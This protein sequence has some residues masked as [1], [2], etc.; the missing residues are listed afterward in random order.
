MLGAPDAPDAGAG[1]G[2]S[3]TDGP[4]FPQTGINATAL[5]VTGAQPASGPFGGGNTIVVRGSGFTDD[6][7]VFIGGRMVQPADTV[8]QD[9]NS[10]EVVVPAGRSGSVS[11]EVR[12]GDQS[13]ASDDAYVYNPIAIEP[14]SGSIAGGTS[15]LISTET[16]RFGDADA[17][18]EFDGKP[19]SELQVITPSQARCK[20]PP[21]ASGAVDISI[22]TPSAIDAPPLVASN[23]FEYR[24]LTD[25]DRGGLN[26]GPISGT[27]NV[28]VVDSVRGLAIPDAFV[29]INDTLAGPYQGRTDS[30]GQITFSGDDLKGRISVH[31]AAKCMERSSIIS[32]DAANVTVHVAPIADPSCADLGAGSSAPGRGTAGSFISGELVFGGTQEFSSLAWDA[33]PRPRSNEVRVAYVFTTRSSPQ[34]ANPTPSLSGTLARVLEATPVL[35]DRGYLYRIFARPAMLAVY[36]IAGVERRD[37]GEFVPYV[38]GVTPGVLTSPGEEEEGVDIQMNI[39]LDRDLQVELSQLPHPAGRSPKYFRMRTYLDLGAEGALVRQI[40][41]RSLDTLTSFEPGKPFRFFAQPALVGPL[42][43]ARYGIIAGWYSGEDEEQAPYTEL[44]RTGVDAIDGRVAVTDLL[45]LPEAVAP[46]FGAQIPED[47]VLRWSI[48]GQAPDLFVISITGGDGLPA[49]TQ[50]VPG[51]QTFSSIPDFSSITGLTDITAGAIYWEVRAVRIEGFVY[52]EF[53][54][55]LLHPR[56]WSHTSLDEFTMRR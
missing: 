20:S 42:A 19:C 34:V 26:G 55:S 30:R 15:V 11:V 12:V 10:L 23:A 29:L 9:R 43:D 1:D 35:G 32:F 7:L 16:A 8:L 14:T 47:R 24:D 39:P 22:S 45:A 13:A 33:V 3:S 49:W 2:M 28:T 25:I 4:L 18:V 38:M 6:A 31:V 40:N 36:A 44:R 53:K 52:D 46:S 41:G 48:D 37:T 50:I 51:H 27:V 17:Q 5:T 21:S 56:L 54:Y